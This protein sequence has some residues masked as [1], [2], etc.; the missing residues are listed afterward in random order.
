[1]DFDTFDTDLWSE[2]QDSLGE[3]FDID[4]AKEDEQTWNDFVNSN[5]TVWQVAPEAPKIRS[6]CLKINKSTTDTSMTYKELLNQLQQLNEEQLNSDV[7]I[8][9]EDDDEFYQQD[10]DLLFVDDTDVLDAGHPIIRFWWLLKLGLLNLKSRL[11]RIVILASLFLMLLLNVW[12]LK[13]VKTLLITLL[14]VLID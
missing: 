6:G 10:V 8:W 11:M 14:S 13:K 5:V 2:I 1:M 4:E 12:I 3:I 9:D 7:C